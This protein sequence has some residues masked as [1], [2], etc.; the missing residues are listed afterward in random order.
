MAD[1][2]SAAGAPPGSIGILTSVTIEGTQELMKCREVSVILAT[3]GMGL[4]RAANRAGR[5]VAI[6]YVDEQDRATR[7]VIWPFLAAYRD[8]TRMLIAWCEMRDDFRMFRADRVRAA[9]FL[10]DR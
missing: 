2:A 1:A 8:T 5:K 9:E 10:E 4:V 7:R 6:D 3:G